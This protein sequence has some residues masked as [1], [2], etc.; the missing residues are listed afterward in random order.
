MPPTLLDDVGMHTAAD[1]LATHITG[2]ALPHYA[3]AFM[4]SR[5]DDPRYQALL[6]TWGDSGQL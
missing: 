5:Y 2:G 3:P 4:L 6:E 1:L